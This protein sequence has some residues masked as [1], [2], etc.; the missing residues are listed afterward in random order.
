MQRK[1]NRSDR[2]KARKCLLP[3]A[4]LGEASLQNGDSSVVGS[5]VRI[6]RGEKLESVTTDAR[7][8][9]AHLS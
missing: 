3:C 9:N 2:I 6:A 1:E 5:G 7:L 4:R 8:R